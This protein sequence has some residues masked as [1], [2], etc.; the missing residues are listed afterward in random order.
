MWAWVLWAIVLFL[1]NAS[2]TWVSRARNSNSIRTH[3][4][5]SVFSNGVF[6]VNLYS[7]VDQI[8]NARGFAQRATVVAF[9]VFWTVLGAVTAHWMMLK[10]KR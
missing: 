10:Q 7:A 3:A 9:Y 2:N 5:A 1:Q 8:H 4:L 6:F